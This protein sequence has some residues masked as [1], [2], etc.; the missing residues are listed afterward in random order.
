MSDSSSIERAAQ[1]PSASRLLE[2][3]F[4]GDLEKIQV[5]FDA[6]VLDAYREAGGFRIIRTDSSGR[7]SKSGAWS[8]DFGIS[9][10]GDKFIHAPI[11]SILHRL[12]ESEH[13][14]WRQ[15]VVSLPLS[16]NFLRGLVRPGCLDDGPIRPW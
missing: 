11:G 10:D 8:I 3:V 4:A 9:G 15:H 5:V 12:P 16:E 7:L 14:H 2:R 1:A 13:E 6:A